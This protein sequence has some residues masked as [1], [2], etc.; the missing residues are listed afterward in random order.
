MSFQRGR[1][2]CWIKELYI[3]DSGPSSLLM[4]WASV[5]MCHA[6]RSPPSPTQCCASHLPHVLPLLTVLHSLTPS[7]SCAPLNNGP[8]SFLFV[9]C[10]LSVNFHT[11]FSTP[12]LS[13]V[14]G[15]HSPLHRC[16]RVWRRVRWGKIEFVRKLPC[17][18]TLHCTVDYNFTEEGPG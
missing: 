14:F 6:S 7:P 18:W 9:Q 17:P 15:V 11:K 12:Y 13:A 2:S 16:T 1:C 8:V 10:K 4:V 3:D 5:M